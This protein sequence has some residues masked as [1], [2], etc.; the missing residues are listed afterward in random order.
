M[1]NG[2]SIELEKVLSKIKKNIT[3]CVELNNELSKYESSAID[4][5]YELAEKIST[6]NKD[7]KDE[8]HKIINEVIAEFRQVQ[9]TVIEE[10]HSEKL[11]ET[12]LVRADYE[13]S[14]AWMD[15]YNLLLDYMKTYGHCSIEKDKK[16]KGM[17]IGR[18]VTDQRKILLNS[19][20]DKQKLHLLQSIKIVDSQII[21]D[22]LDGM[23]SDLDPFYAKPEYLELIDNNVFIWSSH[24][25]SWMSYFKELKK[26]YIKNGH[27]L[28]P[29][30][31][32]T[33]TNLQLGTW[34][35][36]QRQ[37]YRKNPLNDK[38]LSQVRKQEGSYIKDKEKLTYLDR[39]ILL[40]ILD[41]VFITDIQDATEDKLS[42][43]ILERLFSRS[44]LSPKETL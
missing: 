3:K 5:G 18:W 36:R 22:S 8:N 17:N 4:S 27:C 9:F 31:Y 20:G 25:A 11:I 33:E 42:L 43:S 1:E 44:H 23:G 16:Y 28:V 39:L 14:D 41:F 29:A 38:E 7:N 21:S 15:N 32:K 37:E 40:S 6:H 13:A 34:V 26:Y 12:L 24:D 2:M 35:L 19:L 10:F 30:A